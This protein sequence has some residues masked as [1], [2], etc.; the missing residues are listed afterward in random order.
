MPNPSPPSDPEIEPLLRLALAPGLGPL[1]LAALLRRFGGAERILAAPR[2]EIAALPGFGDRVASRV[3]EAASPAGAVRAREALGRLAAAGARAVRPRSEGYPRRLA[4]L[5]DPPLL[6][7]VQGDPAMLSSPGIGIV[8]TR[9]PTA[10]G[11]AAAA[12]LAADLARAGYGVVSGM[13]RGIDAAAHAGALEA[14]GATIGVLG[15]GIDL[16]Y[17]AENR[18]LFR[19]VRERGYLLSE[20]PPGEPPLAGNFPRRNRLIA[21]LSEGVLVV[22]M[23][24]RSGARHT[25]ESALELGREVFA[26]PGSIGSPASVGSNLLLKEGAR[27]VTSARDVVE[28]LR[29]V[30]AGAGLAVSG[31]VRPSVAVPDLSPDEAAVLGALTAAPVHVDDLAAGLGM[32]T[33]RLLPLLLALELRDGVEALPGKRFRAR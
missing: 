25:V 20:L 12:S 23:G 31:G 11:R 14:R 16:A 4:D 32:P 30:G 33:H 26:V 10:D 2:R 6:L 13:A 8:G 24:E 3:T 28:E 27:L 29:G 17:P 1:R 21:A 5:P 7:Y 18:S 9:H 22:E 19:R 15:H